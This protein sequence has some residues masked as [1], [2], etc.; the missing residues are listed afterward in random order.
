[1]RQAINAD[2]AT[3]TNGALFTCLLA[4]SLDAPPL[5]SS[6]VLPPVSAVDCANQGSKASASSPTLGLSRTDALSMPSWTLPV[7]SPLVSHPSQ[8]ASSKQQGSKQQAA[9][10]PMQMLLREWG[11]PPSTPTSSLP[12]QTVCP[13]SATNS[14]RLRQSYS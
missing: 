10:Q 4:R 6:K 8:A 14:H 2:A 5:G 12:V 7:A 9:R 11:C 1:M 13:A 3:A